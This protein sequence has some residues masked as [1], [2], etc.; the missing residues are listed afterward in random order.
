MEYIDPPSGEGV[1]RSPPI[2]TISGEKNWKDYEKQCKLT[3]INPRERIR[4]KF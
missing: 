3:E 2:R 4:N 1:K